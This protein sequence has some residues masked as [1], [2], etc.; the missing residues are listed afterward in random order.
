MIT[1]GVNI[2]NI[3][4]KITP[5]FNRSVIINNVFAFDFVLRGR[6]VIKFMDISCQIRS[7]I[8]SGFKRPFFLLLPCLG[9]G[10]CFVVSDETVVIL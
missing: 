8:R 10:A 4:I 2:D 7:R 5:L 6:F 9:M 1:A 3:G